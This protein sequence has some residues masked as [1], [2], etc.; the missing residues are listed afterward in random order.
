MIKRLLLII[1]FVLSICNVSDSAIKSII[2]MNVNGPVPAPLLALTLVCSG[3]CP[4]YFDGN[5]ADSNLF[6][7]KNTN[8]EGCLYSVDGGQTW[9]SCATLPTGTEPI[10]GYGIA[11][12]GSFIAARGDVIPNSC[13]I[14]RSTDNGTTW[15]QVF[16]QSGGASTCVKSG[17]MNGMRCELSMCVVQTGVGFVGSGMGAVV[18]NDNGQNWLVSGSGS[19]VDS[20]LCGGFMLGVSFFNADRG[21]TP[22]CT[23]LDQASSIDGGNTWQASAGVLATTCGFG[24]YHEPNATMYTACLAGLGFQLVDFR[25]GIITKNVALPTGAVAGSTLIMSVGE[26][27]Y[28]VAQSTN[29]I[30]SCTGVAANNIEYWVSPDLFSS[31]ISLGCFNIGLN[32]IQDMDT[33]GTSVYVSGGLTGT[34]ARLVRLS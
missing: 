11:G 15:V 24:M 9:T 18:S 17:G 5:S 30:D 25:G 1:V 14:S 34:T 3:I 26:F 8:N 22:T 21:I 28:Y 20:G 13:R 16:F 33:V 32:P 27:A 4:G 19:F 6:I 10:H 2:G 23:T 31:F 12:D 7:G 29:V